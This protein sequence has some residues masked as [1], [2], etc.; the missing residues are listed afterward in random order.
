MKKYLMIILL[1]FLGVIFIL[2]RAYVPIKY[3]VKEQDL[4]G[5]DYYLL[6]WCRVTGSDWQL[7]GNQ[8]GLLDEPVYIDVDWDGEPFNLDYDTLSGHN[9]YVAYGEFSGKYA[10]V[11]YGEHI[12]VYT[13]NNWDVL[14][15]VKRNATNFLPK[16]YLCGFDYD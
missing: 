14:Y 8:D 2:I 3:A 13:F 7:I 9:I 11:G 15:P 10:E 6:K 1:L 5:N 12:P 16:S 4:H